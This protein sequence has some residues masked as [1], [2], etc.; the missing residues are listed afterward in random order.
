MLLSGCVGL[1]IAF[2][3][4]DILQANTTVEPQWMTELK[5]EEVAKQ[6]Q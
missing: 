3:G 1:D 2:A 4:F 6:K 5:K